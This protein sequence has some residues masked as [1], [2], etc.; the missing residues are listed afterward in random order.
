MTAPDHHTAMLDAALK[1]EEDPKE[2]WR[3][4]LIIAALDNIIH[5]DDCPVLRAAC[6]ARYLEITDGKPIL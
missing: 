1:L 2:A 6:R 4:S 3:K 5:H